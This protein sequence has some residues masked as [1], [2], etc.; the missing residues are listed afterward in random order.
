[1]KLIISLFFTWLICSWSYTQ[2]GVGAA[3]QR[4]M[5][6]EKSTDRM[7]QR[8]VDW[9]CGQNPQ[10]VDCNERLESN[11]GS[12]LVIHRKSG[13][14][15]TGTCETCH[16]NG[17]KERIVS[18]NEGR[19]HGVDTT[20]YPSGCPQVVRSH[21]DGVEHGTWTYYNDSSGLEAWKMNFQ[22]GEKHGQSIY[23]S[24]YMVG[25][26]ELKIKV[27]NSEQKISYG[28]Y[29]RDT[30]RIENHSNGKLHGTRKE[31]YPGSKIM[32]EVG[33]KNGVMHGPFIYYDK[34]GNILQELN[35]QDG[36]KHGQWKYY[37]DNGQLLRVENWD[38]DI[39]SGEFKVFYIQGHIQKK[40][41]YDNRGRK[42]GWFEERYPDDKVKRRSLY[43]R[44]ELI[45][46]HEFDTYGNE[47]RTVGETVAKGDEDD[48][49]PTKK[50][51]KKKKSKEKKPKGW[52]KFWKKK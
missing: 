39:K 23:Y 3:K 47:I 12:S 41:E 4:R 40:E 35:Y 28:L 9:E 13:Q 1:M 31:Y 14:L 51:K 16:Q 5:C 20:Y 52:W 17:I 42:H 11:P 25:T 7:G 19:V 32:K 15:F 37:Y 48:A 33:Y 30:L 27:G 6:F 10:V 24:H 22:Q 21:I 44:D 46:D 26:N 8:F 45:E 34:D 36:K 38:K 2:I 49:M 29:D 43:R 50:D 18:F